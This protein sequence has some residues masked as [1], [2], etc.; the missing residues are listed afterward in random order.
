[1][2]KRGGLRPKWYSPADRRAAKCCRRGS[3]SGHPPLLRL[4]KATGAYAVKGMKNLLA[5]AGLAVAAPDHV[6]NML[7]GHASFVQPAL[8]DLVTVEIGAQR[9]LE[10]GDEEGR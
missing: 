6:I 4:D 8:D 10:R 1:M 3:S 5:K 9:V 2:S 7:M